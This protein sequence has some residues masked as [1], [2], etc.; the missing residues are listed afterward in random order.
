MIDACFSIGAE[1]GTETGDGSA[2]D[3]VMPKALPQEAIEQYRRDGYYF[4]LPVL[5]GA[6][7]AGLRAGIE[8]FEATQGGAL[9]PA[10]RSKSHLLFKRLDDLI[11]DPRVL[12]PVEDLIGPDILCWNTLFWIK[13][14]VG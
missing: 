12:D 14:V 7:A 4:P 11:R 5:S 8:A 1:T 9:E 10:Q 6:E 3:R 13:G 2:K